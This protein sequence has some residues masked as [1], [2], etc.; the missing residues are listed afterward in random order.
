MTT[1]DSADTIQLSSSY[2]SASDEWTVTASG[3]VAPGKTWTIQAY[4]ICVSS[5]HLRP[6]GSLVE[7]RAPGRPASPCP[8]AIRRHSTGAASWLAG[9]GLPVSSEHDRRPCRPRRRPS[10]ADR[11]RQPALLRA[12]RARDHRR[13]VRRAH[14]RAPGPRGRAPGAG[15]ARLADPA[16]RRRA[17]GDLRRGPPPD[18]DAQPGQRLRRGRAARLRRPRAQGARAAPD[19]GAGPGAELRRRAEDRRPGHLAC[20]TSA[21]ASSRAPPAATARPART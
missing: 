9:P 11:A 2:P 1:T 15:H 18:P 14:A 20:A 6:R 17:I 10:R 19:T 5:E 13:R 3:K 12:G 21:A 8:R 4:A 16:R 7:G